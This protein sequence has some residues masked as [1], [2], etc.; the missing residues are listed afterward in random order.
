MQVIGACWYVLSIE[1]QEACWR[2]VCLIED[3]TCDEKFFDCERFNDP[4]RKT[5]FQTSN[6]SAK[7]IPTSGFYPFGIFGEAVTSEV[8]SAL[9]FNKYF[10]C[11]WFGLK[12]LR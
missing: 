1:R 12:N 9:F 7:C 2:S 11:L 6:V 4:N 10:Y 8:T 3:K 5:W